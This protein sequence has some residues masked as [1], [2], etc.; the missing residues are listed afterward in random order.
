MFLSFFACGIIFFWIFLSYYRQDMIHINK[1]IN[2]KNNKLV[3]GVFKYKKQIIEIL[4][5]SFL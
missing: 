4:V 3:I 1:K 2:E 5:D